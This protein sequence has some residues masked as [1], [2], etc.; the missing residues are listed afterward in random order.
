MKVFCIEYSKFCSG[1][2]GDYNRPTINN[3]FN[4]FYKS[5][6]MSNAPVRAWCCCKGVD[7]YDHPQ[8]AARRGKTVEM[9]LEDHKRKVRKGYE[10]LADVNSSA[11]FEETTFCGSG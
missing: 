6:I 4:N 1:S 7:F 9:T 2:S 11:T 5:H 10:I 8:S 3:L